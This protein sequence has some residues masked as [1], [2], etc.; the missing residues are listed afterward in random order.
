M[1][2]IDASVDWSEM[3]LGG[4]CV[5][6]EVGECVELVSC[7]AVLVCDWSVLQ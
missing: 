3:K 4:F 5:V 1:V 6:C 2:D 7:L